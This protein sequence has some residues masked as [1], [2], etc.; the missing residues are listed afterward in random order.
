MNF[1][2]KEINKVIKT[3]NVKKELAKMELEGNKIFTQDEINFISKGCYCNEITRKEIDFEKV[4]LTDLSYQKA[5]LKMNSFLKVF[6][7]D[8]SEKNKK[9]LLKLVKEKDRIYNDLK[10]NFY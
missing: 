2:M 10:N 8:K 1:D 3:S 5:Y 7:I 6:E 9:T 4:L